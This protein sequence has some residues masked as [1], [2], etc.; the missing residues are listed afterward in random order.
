MNGEKLKY[1]FNT[2]LIL[3]TE[4]TSAEGPNWIKLSTNS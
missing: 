1:F 3:V 4:I 2:E